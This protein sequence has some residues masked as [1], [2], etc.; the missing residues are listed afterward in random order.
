MGY[1][2]PPEEAG[3]YNVPYGTPTPKVTPKP[4]PPKSA[5]TPKRGRL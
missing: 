2:H 1:A 4:A 5:P 3:S